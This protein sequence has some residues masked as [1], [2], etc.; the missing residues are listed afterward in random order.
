MLDD[1]DQKYFTK[2]LQKYENLNRILEFTVR[3]GNNYSSFNGPCSDHIDDFK[4]F[5]LNFGG[6][7]SYEI[8][9]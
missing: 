8:S 3:N 7:R 5:G 2:D 1:E 6:K 9:P 4:P